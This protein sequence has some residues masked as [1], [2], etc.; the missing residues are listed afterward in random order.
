MRYLTLVEVLELHEEIINT[1]GGARGVRD[2]KVLESAVNQPRITFDQADLYPD[3]ASKA[4]AIGFS[5]VMNHPFVD[6]NKR[7]GHAAME[8]L[9]ILNGFEIAADVNV[10]EILFLELA[11]GKVTRQDL[12]N[13]LSDYITAV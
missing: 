12:T 11:S 2:L 6:D 7:V 9:L 13:W 1:T 10:Q 5:L 3:L 4:A 8:T